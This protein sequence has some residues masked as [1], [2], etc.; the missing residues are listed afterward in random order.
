MASI[1]ASLGL[2]IW[3]PCS[4]YADMDGTVFKVSAMVDMVMKEIEI[5]ATTC[6]EQPKFFF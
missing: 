3:L 6:K 5:T 4:S 1:M 2:S